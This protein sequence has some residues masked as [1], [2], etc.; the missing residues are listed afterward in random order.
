MSTLV[1]SPDA[2]GLDDLGFDATT[3]EDSSLTAS[4]TANPVERGA[5]VTDEIR[6]DPIQISA[7]VVITE[8]PSAPTFYGE[9]YKRVQVLDTGDP[10]IGQIGA[11]HLHVPG[12]PGRSLVTEMHERLDKLRRE[13]TTC[14]VI[15][16][17]LEF[18]SMVLTFAQLNRGPN[19]GGK[20][21]FRLQFVEIKTADTATVQAPVPAEPRGQ[22]TKNAGKAPTKDP[23]TSSPEAVQAKLKSE[24]AAL[25]DAAKA[26]AKGFFGG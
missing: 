24:A 11:E 22:K 6:V 25:I 12:K 23:A 1:I 18:P 17:T 21:V 19:S 13:R 7:E 20:G 10:R 15:T 4:V 14:T 3:L 26:A 16:S 5:P 2:P 8:T 9:G